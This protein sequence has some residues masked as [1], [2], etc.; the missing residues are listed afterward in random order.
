MDPHTA[1]RIFEPFF[2]TKI[3]GRGLGLAAVRDIMTTLGGA[4][5]VQS[6]L[7]VGTTFELFFPIHQP[8]PSKTLP[9]DLSSTTPQGQILL[10]DDEEVIR[11]ALGEMLNVA[12]LEVLMAE[13]GE[14]ALEKFMAHNGNIAAVIVDI[15]MPGLNGEQVL[16]RL[17][18]MAPQTP[19]IL[20]SGYNSTQINPDWL[21]RPN[22]VILKKPFGFQQLV[23]AIETVCAV[24]AV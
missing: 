7:G 21:K 18:E 3:T 10:A 2:T 8:D 19:I 9:T 11:S 1:A 15:H 23:Q 14:E 6:Q 13:N 16:E 22:I 24:S 17:L 12:G 4:M 5:G 20:M